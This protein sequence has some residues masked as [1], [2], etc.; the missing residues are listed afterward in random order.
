LQNKLH[1]YLRWSVLTIFTDR[2]INGMLDQVCRAVVGDAKNPPAVRPLAGY[3]RL[4]YAR[5]KALNTPAM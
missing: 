3:C 1:N 2:A 5:M 4:K